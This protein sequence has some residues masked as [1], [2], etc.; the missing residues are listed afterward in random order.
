MAGPLDEK[1]NPKP[2]TDNLW[3]FI[4]KVG[5][6]PMNGCV[7]AKDEDE[8]YRVASRWCELKGVRPPAKVFPMILAGPEI[9]KESVM[10]NIAGVV[11][12]IAPSGVAVNAL[13]PQG[14]Q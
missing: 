13:E 11:G 8:G 7:R 1:P 6:A 10:T 14:R 3:T 12:N 2:P 5:P 4:Y 9:L